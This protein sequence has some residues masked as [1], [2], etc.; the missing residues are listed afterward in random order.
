LRLALL[1]IGRGDGVAIAIVADAV[2][3]SR[4]RTTIIS[5]ADDANAVVF[6]SSIRN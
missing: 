5:T 3:R 6:D 1:V 4:S 2:G